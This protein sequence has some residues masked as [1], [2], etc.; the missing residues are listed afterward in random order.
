[1][2]SAPGK[3]MFLKIKSPATFIS[4]SFSPSSGIRAA[5]AS[6]RLVAKPGPVS[7]TTMYSPVVTSLRI[8]STGPGVSGPGLGFCSLSVTG[9][10]FPSSPMIRTMRPGSE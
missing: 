5:T 1:M 8:A 7:I 3:S 4:C 2:M 6:W 10:A 9:L